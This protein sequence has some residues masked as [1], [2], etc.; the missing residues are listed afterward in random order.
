MDTT[1]LQELF[2]YYYTRTITAEQRTEL[3]LLINEASPDELAGLIT[4]SGESLESYDLILTPDKTEAIL[5][6]ILKGS[7][8]PVRKMFPWTRVAAAAVIILLLSVGGY[9]YF[10]NGHSIKQIAKTETQQQ[11]FKNDINPAN[12][13]VV[14]TLKDGSKIILDSAANGALT[15]QGATKVVKKD[16]TV[17][18]LDNNATEVFFN[19][20][21]TEKGRTYHLQLTDGTEVW[22]DALSSIRFPTAFPGAER[23]VEITGQAYFE[24]AKNAKQ[25]FKV[26]AGNQVV[27]VLGTHFN[28]NAYNQQD[29]QTTLLEGSVK[30]SNSGQTVIIKPGEQAVA[31][32]HSPFTIHHS[33]DLDEVM[34]W[35]NGRFQ[36]NGSTVEEIMN[37]LSRWYDIDVIYQDKV[38][39]IFVAKISKD[40]PVSKLL[41]LLEMTKQVR[42][43]I[44][45]KKITVMK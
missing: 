12:Q 17:S 38:P 32:S 35:K 42:F 24:V 7:K 44:E 41:A 6:H 31:S 14:L 27:E 11:R 43:T 28:I 33:P 22:L 37:Q 5:Q 20:I 8:A 36:F 2:G 40:M 25:P 30:V 19:T 34:A 3:M 23:Q 18:Y 45:G 9:F 39:G 16:G 10:K 1:R 13:Q 21:T 29:M 15:S 26:K 4:R